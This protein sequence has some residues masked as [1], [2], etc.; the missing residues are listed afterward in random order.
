MMISKM[1]LSVYVN[2][3]YMPCEIKQMIAADSTCSL[4][5]KAS[6]EQHASEPHAKFF[7]FKM[8]CFQL[9]LETR[10]SSDTGSVIAF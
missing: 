10:K 9:F 5:F 7:F 1:I 2:M 3:L 4:M 8:C 6:Q